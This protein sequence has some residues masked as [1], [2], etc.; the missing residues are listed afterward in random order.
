MFHIVFPALNCLCFL[1][2]S[3]LPDYFYFCAQIRLTEVGYNKLNRNDHTRNWSHMI[4][5][6]LDKGETRD[7]DALLSDLVE[8]GIWLKGTC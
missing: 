2:V 6:T 4:Q 3:L 5:E 1:T 7:S 8:G